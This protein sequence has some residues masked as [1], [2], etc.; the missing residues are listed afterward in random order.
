MC[1]TCSIN[2]LQPLLGVDIGCQEQWCYLR[3]FRLVWLFRVCLE[4][5]LVPALAE[6]AEQIHHEFVLLCLVDLFR[7]ETK[8][9]SRVQETDPA[10]NPISRNL[11]RVAFKPHT[12]L[13]ILLFQKSWYK[14][15]HFIR[16]LSPEMWQNHTPQV[17]IRNFPKL[18]SQC[19]IPVCQRFLPQWVD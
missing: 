10:C 18:S 1:Y 19:F 4:I 13:D 17:S 7:S 3:A 2:T 8:L 6:V 15:S 9:R 12:C 16:S 5:R 14:S 11:N